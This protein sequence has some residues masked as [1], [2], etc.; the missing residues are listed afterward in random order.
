MGQTLDGAGW[1]GGFGGHAGCRCC[2][3]VV[4]APSAGRALTASVLI[5][6]YGEQQAMPAVLAEL[7]PLLAD[8]C[9]VVVAAEDDNETGGRDSGI[10]CPTGQAAA[11]A[12]DPRVTVCDGG[13]GL[14]GGLLEA[15][16]TATHDWVVVMDG[17]GQH[18]PQTVAELA[19]MAHD[20]LDVAVGGTV[21]AGLSLPRRV[22]SH[23]ATT[24]VRLRLPAQVNAGVKYPLS[25]L[26]ATHRS[27]LI[28][29]L[30]GVSPHGFKALLAVLSA[31]PGGRVREVPSVLR[32]RYAGT[33]KLGWRVVGADLLTLFSV[34]RSEKQP[35]NPP[36][37]FKP[38]RRRPD[39]DP[40]K[41]YVSW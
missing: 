10:G 9:Q 24:T 18:D 28:E 19:A 5:P 41:E 17:D 2:G 34:T 23:I 35:V 14:I 4:G 1:A 26:F 31:V 36:S 15:A 8:D 37:R 6:A 20:R 12:G 27:L 3:L 39:G 16:A 11:G 22:L 7:L 30:A 13:G 40:E 32:E 38:G 33:S 29:A 25:G 21:R